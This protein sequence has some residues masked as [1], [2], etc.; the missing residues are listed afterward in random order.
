MSAA[1]A[2]RDCHC[3]E[4]RTIHPPAPFIPHPRR[5]YCSLPPL[6][7]KHILALLCCEIVFK[8]TTFEKIKEQKKST[9]CR[10]FAQFPSGEGHTGWRS[11]GWM[12]TEKCSHRFLPT[13][14]EFNL[15]IPQHMN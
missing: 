5:L 3:V 9:F 6:K 12:D 4:M 2:R 13:V 14:Y 11:V 1:V 7:N 10:C 8:Y 15:L